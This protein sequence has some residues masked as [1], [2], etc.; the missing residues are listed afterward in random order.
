M[1]DMSYFINILEWYQLTD[2]TKRCDTVAAKRSSDWTERGVSI[3]SVIRG[4]M[5]NTAY[6]IPNALHAV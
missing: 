2:Q 4:Y 5:H 3:V 6:G 1:S